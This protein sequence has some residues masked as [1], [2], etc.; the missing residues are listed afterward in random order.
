MLVLCRDW[1]MH[2]EAAAL[3]A[4]DSLSLQ[5]PERVP[6]AAPLASQPLLPS[7]GPLQDAQA[8]STVLAGIKLLD[9]THSPG[10]S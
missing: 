7:A 8:F 10:Q 5:P 6:G 1:L 2:T 4:R 9:E 3:M